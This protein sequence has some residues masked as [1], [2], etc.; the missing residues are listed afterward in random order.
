MIQYHVHI[1]TYTVSDLS[2]WTIVVIIQ[3]FSKKQTQITSENHNV[4]SRKH[5]SYKRHATYFHS[6]NNILGINI[7]FAIEVNAKVTKMAH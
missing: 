7:L 2:S 1:D 3:Q 6:M 5:Q 4:Q